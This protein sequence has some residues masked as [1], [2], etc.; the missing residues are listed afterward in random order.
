MSHLV[1]IGKEYNMEELSYANHW[2]ANLTRKAPIL[3]RHVRK[4]MTTIFKISPSY[5]LYKTLTTLCQE[6][7]GICQELNDILSCV[8]TTSAA[9]LTAAL[10]IYADQLR[11]DN[12]REVLE[13]H[14]FLLGLE[15]CFVFQDTIRALLTSPKHAEFALGILEFE[16]LDSLKTLHHHV[17]KA[18]SHMDDM[19]HR[20]EIQSIMRM[21]HWSSARS[22]AI[23][24]WVDSA[25]S[26]P[27]PANNT[28]ALAAMMVELPVTV[29]ELED[30]HF[31]DM[32]LPHPEMAEA[33][34]SSPA[35]MKARFAGWI[36]VAE[37]DDSFLPALERTYKEAC[38][39][40]PW[41]RTSDISY[42][43]INR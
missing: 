41:L 9:S 27:A 5:E 11:L 32:E 3:L 6:E 7:D 31:F 35:N 17:L 30:H 12:I 42:E 38:N 18:F 25:T 23:R 15:D 10:K 29:D 2:D 43:M 26:P 21:D 13:S 39:M 37:E 40:M 34:E 1:R 19:A 20:A 14:R 4:R 22:E 8:A 24:R 16:L 28:M 36:A 33:R